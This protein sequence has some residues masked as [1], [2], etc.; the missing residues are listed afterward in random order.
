MKLKESILESMV[1]LFLSEEHE[2]YLLSR[3]AEREDIENWKIFTFYPPLEFS[4]L[5]ESLVVPLFSP[6]GDLMGIE[7]KIDL[8]E[9]S[10]KIFF[11]E[12]DPRPIWFGLPYEMDRVWRQRVVAVVEG[13]LDALVLKRVCKIPVL[14]AGTSNLSAAQILFLERFTDEVRVFFDQDDAG[15][16]GY[17]AAKK[18]VQRKDLKFTREIYGV[19]GDDPPKIWDRGGLNLLLK[20]FEGIT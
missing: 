12:N 5:E 15:D 19:R 11:K 20:T 14:A 10:K 6:R 2:V 9:K 1:D 18:R 7:W 4:Y 3:G 17:W 13:Y 16:K 8:N